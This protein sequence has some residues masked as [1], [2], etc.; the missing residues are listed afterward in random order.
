ME[1]AIIRAELFIK[2]IQNCPPGTRAADVKAYANALEKELKIIK[3]EV[4]RCAPSK[5][6]VSHGWGSAKS[7]PVPTSEENK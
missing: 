6:G 5:I 4:E 3:R 7:T 2:A 1:E